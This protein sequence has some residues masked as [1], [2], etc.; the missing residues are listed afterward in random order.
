MNN[1]EKR[2]DVVLIPLNNK[3]LTQDK[4]PG[5]DP[6]AKKTAEFYE[7]LREHASDSG[8]LTHLLIHNGTGGT[9]G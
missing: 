8:D 6:V 1:D 3:P 7:W 4:M 9:H 5:E 2:K